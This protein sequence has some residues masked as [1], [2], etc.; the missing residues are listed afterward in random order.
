MR[1][2]RGSP[3]TIAS[4]E[5][6]VTT[7]AVGARDGVPRRA[8]PRVLLAAL[9]ALWTTLAAAQEPAEPEGP[10]GFTPQRAAVATKHMAVAANPLAAE[11][12][13]EI[14]RLAGR[15]VDA[16]NAMPMALAP[17]APP[18]SR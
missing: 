14:L 17:V 6:R 4:E 15:A 8:L 13:R 10:S 1:E 11:A 5:I 18:S 9:V 16:V 12:G 2:R 3:P 7:G